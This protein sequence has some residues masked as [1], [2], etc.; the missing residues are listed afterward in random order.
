MLV[1]DDLI[2]TQWNVNTIR[3][4]EGLSKEKRF[5]RYIVECKYIIFDE[6]TA[7]SN[8]L[9]DTQWNVN[10]WNLTNGTNYAKI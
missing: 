9:I 10:S 5:N 4:R 6:L 7:V 1:Y 2:D 3:A 8:D